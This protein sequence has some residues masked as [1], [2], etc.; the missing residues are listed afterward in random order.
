MIKFSILYK[1]YSLFCDFIEDRHCIC[2]GAELDRDE[3]GLCENCVKSEIPESYITKYEGNIVER[4]LYG[5]APVRAAA[6]LMTY[7]DYQLSKPL[8]RELKYHNYSKIGILFGRL[9][10]ESIVKIPRFPAFDFIVPVPLHPARKARR[11]Y[12]QS[13]IIAKEVATRLN[14]KLSVDNLIRIHNNESQTKKHFVE[15]IKNV[16]GIFAVRDLSSFNNTNIL[17][18]DD[19]FTTGSTITSCCKVLYKADNINI[20]VFTVAIAMDDM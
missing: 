8:I 14:T 3:F 19:V 7:N 15:R 5:L 13:E 10:A 16:D 1:L 2:C 9:I 4:K 17:L 20:Y 18:I 6:A 12:N 11:G